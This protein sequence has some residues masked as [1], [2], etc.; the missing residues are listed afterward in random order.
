MVLQPV[1]CHPLSCQ[2]PRFLKCC[3]R[4]FLSVDAILVLLLTWFTIRTDPKCDIPFV[5]ELSPSTSPVVMSASRIAINW[6]LDN[7]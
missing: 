2:I 1:K 4:L 5:D 6:V 7:A 3:R